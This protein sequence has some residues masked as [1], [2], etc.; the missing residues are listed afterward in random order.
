[1]EGYMKHRSSKLVTALIATAAFTLLPLAAVGETTIEPLLKTTLEDLNG[2][3]ANVLVIDVDPGWD[4]GRHIHP[5]HVFIYM[6]E[7]SLQ[8]DIEGQET[9]SISAGDTLYEV[10]NLAMVGRNLSTTER[11]KLLVFQ[12]GPPGAPIMIPSPE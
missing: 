10:A 3:E 2:A 7:G 9:F 12:V 4:S 1:M 6:L 5:G 8:L 11:A